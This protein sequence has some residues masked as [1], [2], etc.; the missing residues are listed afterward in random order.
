[1][2]RL[3]EGEVDTDPSVLAAAVRADAR[4][5]IREI[6]VE[7]SSL[8]IHIAHAL[9]AEG[10][11]VAVYEARQVSRYLR[12]RRNKTDR[13]DALGLAEIA[14]LR[15]PSIASVFVKSP[16]LARRLAVTLLAMWKSGQ[17]FDP[18]LA[19]ESATR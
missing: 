14:K 16:A 11:P 1:M 17:S 6:A 7:A 9:R 8:A 5:Q 15:L 12:L 4:L 18:G 19:R 10:L 2:A 13:N 3:F